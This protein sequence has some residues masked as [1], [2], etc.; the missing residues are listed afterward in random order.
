MADRERNG[1]PERIVADRADKTAIRMNDK[2][3][4]GRGVLFRSY[5]LDRNA[6]GR[7]PIDR[8]RE[9]EQKGV[10]IDLHRDFFSRGARASERFIIARR[11]FI[12]RP[13]LLVFGRSS[14]VRVRGYASARSS[15]DRPDSD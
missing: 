8:A 12:R 15:R 5:L 13:F 14:L 11:T 10:S 2:D 6:V 3:Y 4:A 9:Q 1:R 7:S